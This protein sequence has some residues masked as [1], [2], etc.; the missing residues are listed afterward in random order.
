MEAIR[1]PDQQRELAAGE[2]ARAFAGGSR[3]PGGLAAA[4]E[5]DRRDRPERRV[6]RVA[7]H[8]DVPPG[9]LLGRRVHRRRVD[10]RARFQVRQ[11][12][13]PVEFAQREFGSH[14]R[15]LLDPPAACAAPNRVCQSRRVA[16]NSDLIAV[17]S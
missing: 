3:A 14:G 5:H 8:D 4:R 13:V 17:D 7:L 6:A 11:E 10:A 2:P 15:R 12:L 16:S 9:Q 1:E